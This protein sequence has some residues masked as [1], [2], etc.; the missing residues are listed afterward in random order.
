[1]PNVIGMGLKDA[2]VI[3]ETYGL[4]VNVVGRGKVSRQS[5]APNSAFTKGEQI[6]I[7]LK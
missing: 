1:M 4:K 6:T 3:L 7:T 5:P 2:L